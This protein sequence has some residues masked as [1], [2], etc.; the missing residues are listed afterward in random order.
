MVPG[1]VEQNDDERMNLKCAVCKMKEQEDQINIGAKLSRH[2]S[3]VEAT[4][5][6]TNEINN[7]RSK[8]WFIVRLPNTKIHGIKT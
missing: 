1:T 2:A 3:N 8:G 4:D 7:I 5:E 6:I